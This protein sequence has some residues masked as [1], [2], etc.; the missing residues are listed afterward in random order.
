MLGFIVKLFVLM[1]KV[2]DVWEWLNCMHVDTSEGGAVMSRC[3]FRIV[4]YL[5]EKIHYKNAL[6]PRIVLLFGVWR[7][8]LLGVWRWSLLRGCQCMTSMGFSIRDYSFVRSRECVRF[9]E[10]PLRE[11]LLYIVWG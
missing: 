3:G 4:H 9:L 11:V 1:S 5:E 6:G 2:H 7:W 8:S 10:C